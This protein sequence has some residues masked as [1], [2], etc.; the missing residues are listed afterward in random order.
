MKV[1]ANKTK[2]IIQDAPPKS[3]KE[4]Q[5]LIGQIN[6]LRRFI[7]NVAGQ[8]RIWSPLLKLKDREDFIWTTEH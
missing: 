5:R 8:L 7:S 2:V 6:Y 3:K 4:L 1:D